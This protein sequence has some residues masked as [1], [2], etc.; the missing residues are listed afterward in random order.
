MVCIGKG[1]VG[2]GRRGAGI[3]RLDCRV[4]RR[5]LYPSTTVIGPGNVS[6]SWEENQSKEN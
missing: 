2:S 4:N 1:V 5:G 3:D 6:E